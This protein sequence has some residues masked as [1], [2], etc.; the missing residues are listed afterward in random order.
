M[1]TCSQL[2]RLTF[3]SSLFHLHKIN[4]QLGLYMFGVKNHQLLSKLKGKYYD[5]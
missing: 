5:F 4:M 2:R 1:C 3:S